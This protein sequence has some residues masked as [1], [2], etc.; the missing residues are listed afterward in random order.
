MQKMTRA[1]R[2]E[3]LLENLMLD[4]LGPKEYEA[5]GQLD[6]NIITAFLNYHGGYWMPIPKKYREVYSDDLAFQFSDNSILVVVGGDFLS[7]Y[8]NKTEY[9]RDM[10]KYLEE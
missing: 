7:N 5:G 9:K 2:V 4:V 6:P 10:A 1:E 3:E 8:K